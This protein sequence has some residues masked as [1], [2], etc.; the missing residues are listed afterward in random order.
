MLLRL[1]QPCSFVLPVLIVLGTAAR[2]IDGAR[3]RG[4]LNAKGGEGWFNEGHLKTGSEE[5]S[6][7][8]EW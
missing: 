6:L 1:V 2:L 3:P 5:Q 7:W 8:K 4:V